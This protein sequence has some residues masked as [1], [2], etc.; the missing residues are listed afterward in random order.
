MSHSEQNPLLSV[1]NPEAPRPYFPLPEQ[2]DLLPADAALPDLFRFLDPDGGPDGTGFVSSAQAWEARRQ[3]LKDLLQYYLYGSRMDPLKSDTTVTAVRENYQYH[4][5]EGVMPGAPGWF[6]Y[7]K[8]PVLPEGSYTAEVMDFSAFG[9]GKIYAKVAP[10]ESY[11]HSGEAFPMPGGLKPWQAG[12]T[13]A[14]HPGLVTKEKLPTITVEMTIRDTNPAN[15]PY[16]SEAAKDGVKHTFDLRFP[17]A[18]VVDGVRRDAHASRSGRGYPVVVCLGGLSEAQIV[19]LNNNGYVYLSVNDATDPDRGELAKYELL[20]PPV[21]PV[22]YNDYHFVNPYPVDSGNL[23]HSGW[24]ASR[25]LDALE[26]Y[27]LLSDAEKTALNPDVILPD[28]DVYAS[29]ITGCSNNGKRAIVGGVF[30]T[31]ADGDSRFD[32]IAPSDPGGGGASGFRYATEG[33]LF[34]YEPPIQNSPA[35]PVVHD[36][37]YGFNETTQRAIQNTGEDHWFCDRA[38]IFTVHPEL[39]NHVPIDAHSL[40]AAFATAK[41]ERYFLAWTGEGQDAWL[42]SPATVLN[43]WAAREAWEYLGQGGNIAVIVRDQAHANQDRDMADLIAIMDKAFYGAAVLR[44]KYHATLAGPD[45]LLA[46]DGSGAILP[47]KVF[48]SVRA[49]ERNPYFIPSTYLKWS[50]PGKHTLWTESNSVTAG[51]SLTFTFHSD[52]KRVDLTL[53]DGVFVLSAPVE[54]GLA[55]ISLTPEQAKAGRY[56][57]AARGPKTNKRI[58]ICGWTGSDALRHAITDNSALGHDVGSGIAFTTP[59]VNYDSEVDPP[60]LYLNGERLPADTCDYDNRVL[61][62][63]ETVP[64]GG[65][66]QPYGTTVILFPGTAGYLL[67][68]GEKAVFSLRNAK[69]EALQGFTLAMDVELEKYDPNAGNPQAKPRMRF[70]PTCKAVAPQSPV[71]PPELRQNTPKL[72][73]P[74]GEKRW[75]MLGNWASDFDASGRLKP[76]DEI[77]PLKTPAAAFV[78]DYAA[79][80]RFGDVSELGFTVSF[81]Q[82]VNTRDF[83]IA[84]DTVPGFTFAWEDGQHV[85]VTFDSP[86]PGGSTVTAFV[87]RSA[88]TDGNLLGAPVQ[89]TVRI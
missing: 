19:T 43:V 8:P 14:D 71:W 41:D 3:E 21:D 37:A 50:R 68:L 6:G 5:A 85:R 20:Y 44:R 17:S 13:W 12:D 34:S 45:G 24:I 74:D 65:Y 40:I 28:V 82:P 54:N 75:P 27:L 57:A 84:V 31:G 2:L 42:N 81:S 16:R 87:F 48:A 77:R 70:R 22:V 88:D 33:Q 23:M 83:G 52:A 39:V 61:W 72:G 25:A 18:P 7:D 15:A 60:R 63:G 10:D 32:I 78:S 67:P 89:L 59:L 55:R 9:M 76:L 80:L 86:A 58:E 69:L 46:A 66:L 38:Q 73:L 51:V 29:A 4:W 56:L 11:V 1:C 26:N 47:E 79:E 35:G 36:Y 53:T 49:M 64:Q 30:D 62:N